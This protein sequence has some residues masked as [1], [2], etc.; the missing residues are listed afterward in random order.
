MKTMMIQY[1]LLYILYDLW[2]S[3]ILHV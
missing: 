1:D 2:V 3:F